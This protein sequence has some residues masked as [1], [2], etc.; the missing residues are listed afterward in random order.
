VDKTDFLHRLKGLRAFQSAEQ[1]LFS[2]GTL[3][4]QKRG[5]VQVGQF[6][7][8]DPVD[9]QGLIHNGSC[10]GLCMGAGQG[11]RRLDDSRLA[12]SKSFCAQVGSV[13]E[14]GFFL[15]R[16]RA[17][18]NARQ[19]YKQKLVYRIVVIV[20][21]TPHLWISQ[22]LSTRSGVYGSHKPV[23]CPCICLKEKLDKIWP[24]AESRVFAQ[25][26]PVDM[27]KLIHSG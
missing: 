26:V 17:F 25:S 27:Q 4:G 6:R 24:C 22:V 1:A 9:M 13:A 19:V 14:A 8:F 10:F 11:R 16:V 3:T 23:G 5:C 15:D 12:R 18:K 20:N 7:T 21:G 2:A